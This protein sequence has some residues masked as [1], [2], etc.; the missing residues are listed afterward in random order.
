MESSKSPSQGLFLSKI[1]KGLVHLK[2]IILEI[3]L[4]NK[5]SKKQISGTHDFGISK[6]ISRCKTQI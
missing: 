5:W 3:K 2:N 1:L 4:F 6:H